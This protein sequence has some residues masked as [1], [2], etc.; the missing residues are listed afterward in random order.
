MDKQSLGLL[1]LRLAFGGMMI[2]GHGWPKLIK[3]LNESPVKFGDPIGVG[4]G[5]SLALAV[6][7][8]V[9]CSLLIML[10]LFT[11]WAT[12]PLIITMFVAAFFVHID[13]PF[14]KMEKA[15]L[16]LVPYIYLFLV[17]GGI[18][19]LDHLIDKQKIK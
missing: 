9:V 15:L 11:R 3:L 12:I 16:Y 4:P 18:Y 7:A 17:G 5:A 10:G 8:E 1:L 13:D 19:A 14:A 2:F 6:F